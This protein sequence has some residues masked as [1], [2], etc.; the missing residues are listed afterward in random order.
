MVAQGRNRKVESES[1]V[2]SMAGAWVSALIIVSLSVKLFEAGAHRA[3]LDIPD[4]LVPLWIMAIPVITI[5]SVIM[6]GVSMA[7]KCVSHSGSAAAPQIQEE[8][9]A[10]NDETSKLPS[11]LPL[12]SHRPGTMYC[13]NCGKPVSEIAI[14]CPSCGAPPRSQKN[15]C[16]NCGTAT[17]SVQIMCVKCGASVAAHKEKSKAVAG[18]LGIFL[19][20]LG[21][22]KFYLGYTTQA[23]I[24]LVVTIIGGILTVGVAAAVTWIV[25]LVEG[26]IYLTKSDQEFRE[27][28]VRNKKKWF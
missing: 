6:A 24:T 23:V 12:E 21:A 25:G 7:R 20:H 19:G 11:Q 13:R 2:P 10:M 14:A 17:S 15:F 5:A 26:I 4:W 8:R 16:Y 28:Y 22:H 3:G 1:F 9:N 18:L 27:T